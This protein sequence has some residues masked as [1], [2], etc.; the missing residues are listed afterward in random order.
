MTA[1]GFGV[2]PPEFRMPDAMALG[3]VRL[4]VADLERSLA[5]YRDLLGFRERARGPASA[6]LGTGADA[7]FT[8]IEK[9]GAAP[10]PPSGRLGLFHV[11]VLLP[12]RASL[13]RLIAHL[14]GRAIRPGMSDHDV[15]EAIYLQDPDN[16]GLEVYAD[17]P[18]TAWRRNGRELHMT[19]VPLNVSEVIRSAG[20]RSWTGMP[21][22]TRIGHV[23]LHVGDLERAAAFYHAALGLDLVVWSYPGALFLSAGGY[24]HHLA[25]NVW[26]GP[27][28]PAPT[29]SDA[30][31]LEWNIVLPSQSAVREAA[32]HLEA[33]GVALARHDAAVVATDPWGTP[34]R[35]IAR[36]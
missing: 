36:A 9:R 3:G 11:A 31:L 18:R 30:R 16:L 17:R 34:V 32:D 5:F 6:E 2:R 19:T 8:L 13:G 21:D 12:D 23:H 20:D 26:A 35:V 10:V 4:Q 27:D 25:V 28:A 33:A 29:E 14:R 15:S 7:L 1:G 22:G 24:H